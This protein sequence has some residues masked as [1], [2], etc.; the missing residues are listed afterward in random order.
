MKILLSI[1]LLAHGSLHA[2][3]ESDSLR[4][5]LDDRISQP[6]NGS[7]R[8]E[9]VS[10]WRTPTAAEEQRGIDHTRALTLTCLYAETPEFEAILERQVERFDVNTY[11]PAVL[12]W[13]PV[14]EVRSSSQ[15]V[16]V[17]WPHWS[18]ASTMWFAELNR[19][20]TTTTT[21]DRRG[22]SVSQAA[23]GELTYQQRSAMRDPLTDAEGALYGFQLLRRRAEGVLQ[24]A[25]DDLI[26]TDSGKLEARVS[27]RSIE[28]VRALMSPP[29][30]PYGYDE[31]PGE[32]ALEFSSEGQEAQLV[33]S[34]YDCSGALAH[35]D[36][37]VW[38]A[39]G[40][41]P[42]IQQRTLL[43]GT[44]R[45]LLDQTYA[46]VPA[47]GVVADEDTFRWKPRRH[48]PIEDNR[49][50]APIRYVAIDDDELPTDSELLSYLEQQVGQWSDVSRPRSESVGA[51]G[52]DGVERI[53][54]G[55]PLV[56]ADARIEIGAHAIGMR[57][58]FRTTL[59]NRGDE[60]IV[61]GAPEG[62]CTCVNVGLTQNVV[63][64]GG[65]VLLS[66]SRDVK[67]L[68]SEVSEVVIPYGED[69][70]LIVELAITGRPGL[71]LPA[72]TVFAH[73]SPSA[74]EGLDVQIPVG[75]QA[76]SGAELPAVLSVEGELTGFLSP[77]VGSLSEGW[78]LAGTVWPLEPGRYGALEGEVMIDA[79]ACDPE[80]VTVQVDL[81]PP[82]V[83][84]SQWP[85]TRIPIHFAADTVHVLELPGVEIR[86]VRS[87]GDA[88]IAVSF[89]NGPNGSRL[90][91]EFGASGDASDQQRVLPVELETDLGQV[92][93]V[94]LLFDRFE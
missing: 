52:N 17:D 31:Y 71:H 37:M 11:R 94:Y 29:L 6:P 81:P 1:A 44:D 20:V 8:V 18:V 72:R 51:P 46:G 61:L 54:A 14:D 16:K 91:A 45:V 66:G 38:S 26:Y 77:G 68:G 39:G 36:R 89:E 58:P 30:L 23:D 7:F 41:L 74:S 70:A 53:S 24:L 87:T 2:G 40:G 55:G 19:S 85:S 92:R 12:D 79:G 56:A 50:G 80:R 27:L 76:C 3:V 43:P 35:D 47:R 10:R 59:T 88:R 4:V 62:D 65:S 28:R 25:G 33:L 32:V 48:T 22:R 49:F 57:V 13:N 9:S 75:L 73:P 42:F 63:P 5:L 90:T 83:D 82:G 64:P 34:W 69:R 67:N 84:A 21:H 15:A 78:M 60:P 93:V 86:E